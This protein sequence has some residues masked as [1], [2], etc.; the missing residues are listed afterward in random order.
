VCAYIVSVVRCRCFIA[1][2]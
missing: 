2:I 1:R